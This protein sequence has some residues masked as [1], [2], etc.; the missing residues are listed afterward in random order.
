MNDQM[1]SLAL[2]EFVADPLPHPHFAQSTLRLEDEV[3]HAYSVVGHTSQTRQTQASSHTVLVIGQTADGKSTLLKAL[4]AAVP[5]PLC[6]ECMND[7][8]SSLSMQ[9]NVH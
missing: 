6:A 7:Q 3:L 5:F 2:S 8:M 4:I 1:S 9:Q